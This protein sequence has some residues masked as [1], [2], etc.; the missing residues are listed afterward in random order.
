MPLFTP[1]GLPVFRYRD[2][3]IKILLCLLTY[4]PCSVFG[5]SFTPD[6]DWRFENFNNQNHFTNAPVSQLVVDKKGYVWT[7]GTGLRRFDGNNTID[8]AG[9]EHSKY[10]LRGNYPGIFRDNSGNV[11]ITCR[12]ICRYNEE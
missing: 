5:Q 3:L 6:P 12:G 8:F 9:P 1:S 7:C 4:I 10:G 11:W 2:S